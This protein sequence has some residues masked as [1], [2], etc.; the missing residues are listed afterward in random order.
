MSD[1]LKVKPREGVNVR[2]VE[3]GKH[4]DAKGEDVPNNSY[5]RRRIK[6]GDLIDINAAKPDTKVAVKKEPK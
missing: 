4:I 6:D 5:Y 1:K 3:S 2:R